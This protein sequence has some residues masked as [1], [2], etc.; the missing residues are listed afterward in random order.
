MKMLNVFMLSPAIKNLLIKSKP[1]NNGNKQGV[2]RKA[3]DRAKQT[4]GRC[5]RPR[6]LSHLFA[7]RLSA[8]NEKDRSQAGC[9]QKIRAAVFFNRYSELAKPLGSHSCVDLSC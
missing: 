6:S 3:K 1:Q 2:E 8:A 9:D 5:P 7:T 4:L